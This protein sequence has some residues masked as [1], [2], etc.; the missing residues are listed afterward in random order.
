VVPVQINGKTR[1][2]IEVPADAGEEETIQI[3]NDNPELGRHL[4]GAAIGR[5]VVVPG[6]IVNVV[7]R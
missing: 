1:F 7:T 3:L 2:R 4:G 5:L 6:R